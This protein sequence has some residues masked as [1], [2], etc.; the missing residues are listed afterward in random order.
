MRIFE[1][2]RVS[3]WDERLGTLAEIAEPERWHNLR[4]PS[5]EQHPILARYVAH[6]F[7]RAYDQQKVVEADQL[8]CFNTGLL[9]RGHEEI[10][11]IFTISEE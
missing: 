10:F 3:D 6:T 11:G 7:L 2:A 8:A 5:K 1:Y 9:T 4:L